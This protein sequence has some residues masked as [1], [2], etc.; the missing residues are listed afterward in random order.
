MQSDDSIL[1]TPGP[2]PVPPSV[3]Q[4]LSMSI[5][6]HRTPRFQE[7]LERV[8]TKLPHVFATRERAFMHVSTGTGGMESLLVNVLS[9]GETVASV[10]SGKFGERWADMAEAYGAKVE[11]FQLE[12]G[13]SVQI[14]AFEAWLKTVRPHIVLSQACETSTG[15]LHPI[16]EMAQAIRRVHPEALFL[17]DAI[18]ALGALPLPMDEWGLDGVVGG[19]QKAFMIPTGLS[20]LALS[21]RAW[22]RAETA[23]SPRFY[24]DLREERAAN[25]RGETNFSSAV[26]LVKALDVVLTEIF[27]FGLPKLYKRIAGLA[28]A[29]REACT[30]MGLETLTSRAGGTP[31]PTLTA[32]LA[33]SGVDGQKWRSTLESKHRVVLMG[34]QDSLKGK[35]IRI[36]HMG[37]ILNSDQLIALKA[38]G[39]SAGVET[40]KINRALDIATEILAHAPL[41]WSEA[42]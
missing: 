6:H 31:S 2:V 9:P 37:Y 8:L 38:I 20:F 36:G 21:E 33:P 12:W 1:M 41:P 17:V 11:R 18:T 34:G 40:A 10:V 29:T 3:L 19:S 26:P 4:A 13:A 39:E 25:L 42:Q 28:Q 27:S 14:P 5:E 35:I 24:F 32:I 22:K 30:I 16:R 7:C 23:R 15:A